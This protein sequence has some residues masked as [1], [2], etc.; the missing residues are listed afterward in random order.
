LKRKHG[1]IIVV[2][3]QFA[4]K[5]DSVTLPLLPPPRRDGEENQKEN[6]WVWM[7]TV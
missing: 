3:P 2:L 4:T 1:E 7:T 6:S 5:N